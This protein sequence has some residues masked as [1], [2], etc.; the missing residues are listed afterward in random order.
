MIY[1]I[2]I[3]LL[4]TVFYFLLDTI[5]TQVIDYKLYILTLARYLLLKLK[6]R[7]V[8]FVMNNRV[9]KRL[10]TFSRA[11]L[12][13]NSA[14]ALAAASAA[15]AQQEL[16][17][18]ADLGN[19]KMFEFVRVKIAK[20]SEYAKMLAGS[21]LIDKSENARNSVPKKRSGHRAVC[22]E[23]NLW[24]WG[25]YCPVEE[26]SDNDNNEDDED[27]VTERVPLF[28]EVTEHAA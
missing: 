28:P 10:R 14:A 12:P 9:V 19:F 26:L 3:G 5:L 4:C 7:V 21:D 2:V 11:M 17:A 1:S 8:R 22:N 18:R 13:A 23:E 15:A 16:A 20:R 27:V 25:G 6:R 24:I